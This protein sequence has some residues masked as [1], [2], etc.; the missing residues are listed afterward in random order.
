MDVINGTKAVITIDITS[1]DEYATLSNTDEIVYS[2][3]DSSGNIVDNIENKKIDA[4]DLNNPSKIVIEIPSTANILNDGEDLSRRILIVNYTMEGSSVNVRKSYRIIPFKSYTCNNEDVRTCLG[5]P[6]TVL[7]DQMIDIYSAYLK[8][9]SLFEGNL[10]DEALNSTEIK[11][12]YANRVIV[13]E[14]AL[15]FRNSLMLMTPKIESDSVVSQTRFTMSKEDFDALFD[16]LNAELQELIDEINDEDAGDTY[17]PDMFVV[18]E[19]T[20]T[21][22]GA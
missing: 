15:S 6:D 13:I 20:D 17:S 7:E 22:T 3:F 14:A 19:L 16:D 2:L 9:K 5:V 10:F 1:N 21:F 18:G 4:S 8:S 11:S 12:V